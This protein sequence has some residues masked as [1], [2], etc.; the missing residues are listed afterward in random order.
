VKRLSM[1]V[2]IAP[3]I[4]FRGGSLAEV[5][6]QFMDEVVRQKKLEELVEK[7]ALD[8]PHVI[9]ERGS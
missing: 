4:W 9:G 3:A 5:C 2:G 6:S 8:Y 1:D 7:F